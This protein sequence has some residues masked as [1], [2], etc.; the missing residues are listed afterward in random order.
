[1]SLSGGFLVAGLVAF[2]VGALLPPSR[3]FTG[4]PDEQRRIV[5]DDPTRWMRS[6]IAL[7]T[8]VCVTFAGIA[9][10]CADLIRQGAW[11]LPILALA[12]FGLGMTLLLFELTFRATVFVSVA[13]GGDEMRTLFGP[14][15]AW[16]GAAYSAYMPLAYL[17]TAAVGGAIVQTSLI[18][19]AFGWTAAAFGLL[20]AGVYVTRFPRPLWTFF[21]IPGL[22]YLLT[23]AIGVGL[24]VG[25]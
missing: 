9:L 20:G 1:V 2:A 6:A 13:R 21:D 17:G 25:A 10:L 18:A 22:L 19:P 11:A 7:G 3:A 12:F 24:L 16:T 14:L 5:A 4:T 8:G 23:G 15:H